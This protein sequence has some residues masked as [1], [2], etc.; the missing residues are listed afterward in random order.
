MSKEIKNNIKEIQGDLLGLAQNGHFDVIVHGCN[1]FNTMGA[2]IAAGIKKLFPDAYHQDQYTERGDR[3]KLGTYT[4]GVHW[5]ENEKR[6][7]TIV[8]AYTQYFYGRTIDDKPPV[9]YDAIERA[10][11]AVNNEFKYQHV[12]IPEIGCGLAGGEWHIVRDI[13]E[14]TLTDVEVTIVHYNG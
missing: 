13:I 11:V 1:C 6:Y 7:L 2:G 5:L 10:L 12:G 14:R 3:D 9:D 8:N 4:K